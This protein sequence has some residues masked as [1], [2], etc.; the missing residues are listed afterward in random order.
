MSADP[1]LG[2]WA[3]WPVTFTVP[4]EPVTQ[5]NVKAYKPDGAKFAR[6]TYKNA[7]AVERYRTDCRAAAAAASVPFLELGAIECRVTF[8]L[9]RPGGH[10]G[11]GRNAGKLKA[12]APTWHTGQRPDWDKLGRA[13]SDA[14]TGVA[15]KDD[16]QLAH[17]TVVKRYVDEGERPRVVVT[18]RPLADEERESA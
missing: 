9:S 4:G 7:S 11:T 12:S 10:Y 5:G 2:S 17:V 1:R 16:G 13:I 14:L 3:N 18:Y 6:I 8:L 15:W